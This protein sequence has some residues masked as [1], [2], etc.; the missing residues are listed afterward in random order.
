MGRRGGKG[1][2]AWKKGREGRGSVGR[3]GGKGGVAWEEG[4]GREG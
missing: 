4:E 2:V 3:R 1:G